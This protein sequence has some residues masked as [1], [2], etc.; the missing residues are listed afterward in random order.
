MN[1]FWLQVKRKHLNCVAS[2]LMK[3]TKC[4]HNKTSY[5]EQP[6]LT[7]NRNTVKIK[8]EWVLVFQRDASLCNHILYIDHGKNSILPMIIMIT[9]TQASHRASHMCTVRIWGFAGCGAARCIYQS[10]Y[11]KSIIT[12]NIFCHIGNG[13]GLVIFQMVRLAHSK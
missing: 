10:I 4:V 9:V 12:T 2:E 1:L 6:K 3:S 13:S 5:T 8:S 7:I 11:N